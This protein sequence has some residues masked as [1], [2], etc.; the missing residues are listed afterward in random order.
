MSISISICPATLVFDNGDRYDN[1]KLLT[2]LRAFISNTYPGAT[3]SCLQIGHRQGDEW[4]CI[5]GDPF[6]GEELLEEFFAT[7]GTD[8]ELFHHG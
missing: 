8:K 1:D 5:D 4:A 7:R 2:A 6:A 3:I